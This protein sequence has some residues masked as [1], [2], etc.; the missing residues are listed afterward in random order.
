MTE[1][2]RRLGTG[3]AAIIGIGSMVGAGVFAVLGPAASAAGAGLLIGLGI[4][5]VVAYCNAVASAQLAA[6][7]PVS[8][9]T[10][11]YGRERLGEW[12]GFS[13]G[14]C[15]VIG[16]TAS[17][18]AMATTFGAYAWPGSTLGPRLLGVAAVLVLTAVAVSGITRTARLTRLLVAISL[19]V[20][21]LTVVLLFGQGQPDLRRLVVG[22]TGAYGVLQSAGLLFFAFA[23]YARIA[24]LGEEV[25][26]PA[27][28]IPRAIVAALAVTLLVYT[29]VALGA[30]LT[31][32]PDVLAGAAAP[33]SEAVAAV[34]A[35]WMRPVVAVGAAVASLGALLALLNGVGRTSLAMGRNRDLPAVVGVLHSGAHGGVPRNAQLL[36]GAVV[37]VLVCTVDLRGMIGF[38]S[39]GVL[40][41][42]AVA[43][44]SALTQDQAHRRYPRPLQVLG[45]AGC[46][47]LAATLPATSVWAGLAMVAVGLSG[48]WLLLRRRRIEH[49]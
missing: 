33:L 5:A 41:Y 35:G 16:K 47:V 27:R 8:G 19:T 10:Y 48:R 36:V 24:T 23:G 44:A 14:W 29:A 6:Q 37:V 28:V 42:Y 21:A 43:N 3:D 1:L 30:L 31:A 49:R 45:V 46:L 22:D 25:R 11:V 38:S 9:G 7:Y 32:G 40:L 2:Q 20:L 13:A 39:F 12:W 17:C 4:A 15:F 34:G 26:D 18:A